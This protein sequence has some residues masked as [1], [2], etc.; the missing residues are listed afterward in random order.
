MVLYISLE[1]VY[2]S[3]AFR[4]GCLIRNSSFKVAFSGGD[5]ITEEGVYLSVCDISVKF[6]NDHDVVTTTVGILSVRSAVLC[7]KNNRRLRKR[8]RARCGLTFM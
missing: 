3:R 4:E 5:F 7:Q 6:Y 1:R 8:W 2:W